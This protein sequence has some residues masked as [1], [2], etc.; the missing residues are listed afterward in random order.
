MENIVLSVA[1]PGPGATA[2]GR[3]EPGPDRERGPDRA[4]GQ[5][6]RSVARSL[7]A[8]RRAYAAEVR[9]L[10]DASFA[11]ARDTGDLEPTVGAIVKAAG[12][13]NKAF[14][15]HFQSKDELL[16]AVLDDGIQQLGDYL[17]VRMA[18]VDSPLSQVRAWIAGVLEQAL[19]PDAAARTRPFAISRARLADRFPDE[20]AEIEQLLTALLREAV[21]DARAAGEVA[22]DD[23]AADAERIYDLAMGWLERRL[24]QSGLPSREDAEHLVGF[25]LRALRPAD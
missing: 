13:S 15:R 6:R 5:A 11:L 25:C 23:P 18:A 17:T 8:R 24:A 1:P 16:L 22:S 12:L 19:N 21:E 2:G 4:G 20:V 14:Y 10:I 7:E 9:S 3:P